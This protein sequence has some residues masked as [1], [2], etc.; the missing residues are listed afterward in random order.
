METKSKNTKQLT[1]E[2]VQIQERITELEATEADLKQ[3]ENLFKA[4]RLI[5]ATID[6][7]RMFKSISDSIQELIGF[8]NF[9][10]FLISD[11][12]EYFHPVC[13]SEGTDRREDIIQ[14]GEELV[15]SVI[16]TGEVF[17]SCNT[18][19]EQFK[20]VLRMTDFKSHIV[21]P[22]IAESECVGALHISKIRENAYN[23]QDVNVLKRLDGVI[24]QA[25]RNAR[26][27][28]ELEKYNLE[29]QRRIHEQSR[30]IDTLLEVKKKL[31]TEI[32]WEKG[33][34]TIVE[35]VINLGF[36]RCGI[37]L[38]NLLRKTLDFHFGMGAELPE[39]GTSVPLSD[40]EYFGVRC[41]R[42]MRTIHVTDYDPSQ[43]RQITSESDSFVW[44]PIIFQGEVFAA[45]AADNVQSKRMITVE[46]V[47]DLEILAG[48]CAAFIDRTRILIEPV[49]EKTLRTEVTHWLDPLEGYIVIEKKTAKSFEIFVDLVTHGIPGFVVSREH[50]KKIRRKYNLVRTPVMWLSR[51][52][53]ENSI[54]PNDLPKMNHIIRNFTQKS[55]ES[56]ILLDGLEYLI[57]Q[58]SFD[59]VIKYLQELKDLIVLNN[60]RLIIPLHRNALT[61]K[62][63][64]ILE[65]EFT[66]LTSERDI[67]DFDNSGAHNL[68]P[69]SYLD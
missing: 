44:V 39:E 27:H 20:R 29:L 36:E 38:V 21:F 13:T 8:D 62:E 60:S 56:V 54:T 11:D 15:S 59:V 66:I 25:V 51:S 42:E 10:I 65:K 3:M 24:S 32:G 5:G 48:M 28:S 47:K 58:I 61:D 52:K 53:I 33:M 30:K 34:I 45:L 18:K 14:C 46:D 49:A 50:P 16:K 1:D 41:I 63:Y 69:K 64:S 4:S 19:D 26:L 67:L 55:E 68:Q 31:Q 22:L 6:M 37:L 43:G 35:S 9:T 2:L 57:T 40:L 17:F 7:E 23:R 12:G